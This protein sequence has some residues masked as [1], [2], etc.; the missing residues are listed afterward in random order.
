[1][2]LLSGGL[3]SAVAAACAK[4]EGRMVHAVSFDYGQRHRAELAAAARVAAAL[5]LDS[6]RVLSVDLA[7]VGGSALTADI[8]VPKDRTGDE[9]GRGVPV[10]Y[11]PARNTVFLALGLALAEVTGAEAIVIGANWIDSSGYPDCREEFLRAFE[12]LANLGTA[13]RPGSRPPYR[14]LAPLIHL[15]KPMIIRRGLELNV[16]FELT[17]SCYDPVG[18]E[19]LACGACDACFLRRRGFE[20]AQVADPTRYAERKVRRPRA[21]RPV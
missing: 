12:T 21:K 19:A 3:D 7:S 4:A 15:T 8:A 1:V 20:E 10:T 14:V 2:A 9:I 17:H 6:H 18:P 11:V 16:P 13:P 5:H